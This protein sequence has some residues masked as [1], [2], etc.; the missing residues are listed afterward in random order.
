[1]DSYLKK[2]KINIVQKFI[3]K[4]FGYLSLFAFEEL[5]ILSFQIFF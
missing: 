5:R 2:M 3:F 4:T 1:M